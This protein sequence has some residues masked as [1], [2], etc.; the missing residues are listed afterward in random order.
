MLRRASFQPV[1][2]EEPMRKSSLS[3]I[4]VDEPVSYPCYVA[5]VCKV[6]LFSSGLSGTIS[7]SRLGF[8][9]P[10]TH[11]RLPR[12]ARSVDNIWS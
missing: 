11:V 8:V 6:Q 7:E 4:G 12:I 5:G 1:I 10:L 2:A 9:V 3:A